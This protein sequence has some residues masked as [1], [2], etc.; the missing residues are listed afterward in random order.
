M[1]PKIS[2]LGLRQG[3]PKPLAKCERE[4]GLSSGSDTV[5]PGESIPYHMGLRDAQQFMSEVRGYRTRWPVL[6]IA[7]LLTICCI[8]FSAS[9]VLFKKVRSS[10][11]IPTVQVEV[12]D[13]AIVPEE[14][15]SFAET[16]IRHEASASVKKAKRTLSFP[17]QAEAEAAV[18]RIP[19]SD[20]LPNMVAS[21]TRMNTGDYSR[22]TGTCAG[23]ASIDPVRPECPE[24]L[25][26]TK[27]SS[28][29]EQV[30]GL[31]ASVDSA[32]ESED[33]EL[34]L[35]LLDQSESGFFNRQRRKAKFLFSKF[36]GIDGTYSDVKIEVL[37]DDE[38]AV[39]LHCKVEAAFARS[40]RPIVLFDGPQNVTLKKVTGAAW[41]ICA[42]D[43]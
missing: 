18:E 32:V 33:M 12:D 4:G 17:F 34:F 22:A 29:V 11:E 38:V 13:S 3:G 23:S 5:G 25:P 20:A 19:R 42:I 24:I 36:D 40:G 28:I 43:Y 21:E 35:A 39:N 41:K 31:L 37:N 2:R 9:H 8:A 14:G 1:N 30:H 6:I 7:S 15:K 26:E 10:P 27:E 16:R